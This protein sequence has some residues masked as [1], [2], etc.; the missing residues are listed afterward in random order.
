MVTIFLGFFCIYNFR[1]LIIES[2]VPEFW[3]S[4]NP[5]ASL[6]ILLSIII[7]FYQNKNNRKKAIVKQIALVLLLFTHTYSFM[8]MFGYSSI[9]FLIKMYSEKRINISNLIYLIAV[10]LVFISLYFNLSSNP[11]FKIFQKYY[12]L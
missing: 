3:F 8:I 2:Q 7:M 9:K 4:R 6:S 12:V 11:G 10:F 1:I 5:V